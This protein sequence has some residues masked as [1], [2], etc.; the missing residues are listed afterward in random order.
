MATGGHG[1]PQ[2]ATA[3]GGHGHGRPRAATATSG[4]GRPR[5]ATGGHGHGRPR[6]ATA[7]SG[8]GTSGHGRPRAATATGGHGRSQ[9]T[10]CLTV[11]PKN[12]FKPFLNIKNH[13]NPN[14]DTSIEETN[15]WDNAF[16][17]E[18]KML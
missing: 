9:K 16:V 2:T 13:E 7:T 6:A 15:P 12:L 4:H 18:R 10:I 14:V 8:H 5:A 11:S 17:K 3:T 1:Q